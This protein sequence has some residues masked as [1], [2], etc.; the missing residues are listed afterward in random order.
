MRVWASCGVLVK[1]GFASHVHRKVQNFFL[2]SGS[3][4]QILPEIRE[5]LSLEQAEVAGAVEACNELWLVRILEFQEN[6]F[7]AEDL[8]YW[9]THPKTNLSCPLPKG[10]WYEG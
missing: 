7:L 2:L 6:C 3:W 5:S 1:E 8:A 9:L 4:V 10:T